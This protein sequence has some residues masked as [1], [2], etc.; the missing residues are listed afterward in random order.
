MT[1]YADNADDGIRQRSGWLIPLGVF[2]ITFALAALFLLF[3]LAPAP[4]SFFREQI[5]FSSRSDIVSL[6]VHGHKFYIPANY[7]KYR[8][9]RQGGER[10]EVKLAAILPDMQGYSSWDDSSFKSNAADSPVVEMLVH[11][12]AVMLSERDWLE[13]IYMPYVANPKGAPGPF[14]LTQYAFR[15]DTGY[16]DEDLF[17]GQG[18]HGPMVIQCV[19]LSQQVPSPACHRELPIAHGVALGYRFKRAQLARGREI[20][21]SVEKLV[22]SF[23]TKPAR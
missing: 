2:L 7:L 20:G 17:I 6:K 21:D 15:R 9:D 5:S 12:D 18:A 10:P 22:D 3:Y 1:R 13:R 23:R 14:G 8:S 16:R 11:D 4:P 19:R